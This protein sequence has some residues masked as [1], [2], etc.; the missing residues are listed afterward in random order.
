MTGHSCLVP[1]FPQAFACD[2]TV[3]PHAGTGV[4]RFTIAPVIASAPPSSGAS[5]QGIGSR[6]SARASAA[7]SS[8]RR[9]RGGAECVP[10][11]GRSC[12]GPAW[13]SRGSTCARSS[14]P[15]MPLP[16]R[17]P[18]WGS[19]LCAL[20]PDFAPAGQRVGAC[21]DDRQD[22]PSSLCHGKIGPTAELTPCQQ[23]LR[24]PPRQLCLAEAGSQSGRTRMQLALPP[25]CACM[26][27]RSG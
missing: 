12:H 11:R 8:K 17:D 14:V 27:A 25:L 9:P 15:A 18:N 20:R 22:R 3:R 1:G 16:P 19:K 23:L 2:A 13:R 10:K 4:T 21:V 5:T 7:G 6:A 26:E 24:S